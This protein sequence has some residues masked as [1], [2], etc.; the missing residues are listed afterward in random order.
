MRITLATQLTLLRMVALPFFIILFIYHQVRW[1]FWVF[2]LASVTD[3]LDGLIARRLRQQT[4]LGAVLDPLADK[5]LLNT[6]FILMTSKTE[7]LSVSVP[8][9]LTVVVL[10]RDCLILL[11]ALLMALFAH[12]RV[13]RPTFLG[14]A[15]AAAQAVTV[16]LTLGLN[17]FRVPAPWVR[18]VFYG[19]FSLTVLSGLQYAWRSIR[20]LNEGPAA[21]SADWSSDGA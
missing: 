3:F 19:T 18:W 20:W 11:S 8:A 9:W 21:G 17:A 13:F 4:P 14:K 5:L 6:C 15:T 16:F 2:T 10:S 1:A 7:D 12:V